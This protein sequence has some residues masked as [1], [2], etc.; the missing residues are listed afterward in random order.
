MVHADLDVIGFGGRRVTARFLVDSGAVYSVLPED[1][2]RAIGLEPTRDLEF[3]LADGTSIHR[4]IS[5]C[6]FVYQSIEAPSP[7]VLGEGDDVALLGSVTLET[8]G[9]ILNPLRRTLSPMRMRLA[10]CAVAS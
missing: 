8:L 1:V 9:L 7:V 6:R 4:R 2:W 5:D 3:V 10:T